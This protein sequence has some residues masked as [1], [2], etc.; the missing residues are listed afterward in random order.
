MLDIVCPINAVSDNRGES[1]IGNCFFAANWIRKERHA[2]YYDLWDPRIIVKMVI[3]FH[4][5]SIS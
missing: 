5:R 1:V 2:N 4:S 3:F